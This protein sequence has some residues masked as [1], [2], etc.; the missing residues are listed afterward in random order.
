VNISIVIAVR[1]D[2]LHI[3]GCLESLSRQTITPIEII[4]VDGS[5]RD[6][7]REYL[8]HLAGA[9]PTIRLLDNPAGDA[10]SGR[11]IGIEHARGD[12]IAFI[13]SDAAAEPDW[14]QAIASRF[15]GQSDKR[16]AGIGGP[17]I[18]ITDESAI[19]R[20]INLVLGSPLAS[21]GRLNPSVQ[22]RAP[23]S[24]CLVRHVPTCNLTVKKNLFL[25]EGMFDPLMYKAEDLEFSTRLFNKGYRFLYD[26]AIRVRHHKKTSLEAFARQIFKWG[27]GKALVMKKHGPEP[28]CLIPILAGIAFLFTIVIAVAQ[29]D[30]A[31]IP[32]GLL[33]AYTLAIAIESIRL[34]GPSARQIPLLALLLIIIHITGTAGIVCG[35]LNLP[36][37]IKHAEEK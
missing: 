10:A 5:S 16:V 25:K 2:R 34:A 18:P 6:G 23:D 17:D 32:A 22:H 28:V 24:V 11:N 1:N 15:A 20:A 14:L 36:L 12:L 37:N 4:I 9:Q 21:G 30:K 8:E 31:V 13:D 3:R 26:P 35:L 7:T 33:I 27:Y 29:P 19:S